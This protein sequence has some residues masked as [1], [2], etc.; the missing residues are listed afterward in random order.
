M[1]KIVIVWGIALFLITL[2]TGLP[3]AAEQTWEGVININTA[4]AEELQLL[5]GIGAV[6][7]QSIITF[8]DTNGPFAGA[9]G[10]LKVKGIGPAKLEAVRSLVTVEGPTTLQPAQ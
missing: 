6:T 1:R 3:H 4:S 7:A 5:P 8:R 2:A 10:L 9:D